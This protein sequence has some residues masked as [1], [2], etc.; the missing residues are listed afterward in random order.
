MGIAV[1][2]GLDLA[3]CKAVYFAQFPDGVERQRWPGMT[4]FHVRPRWMRHCNYPSS[5]PRNTE[6]EL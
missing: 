1:L 6:L 3:H 4:Y 2:P 5:P